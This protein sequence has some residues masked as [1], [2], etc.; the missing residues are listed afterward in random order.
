MEL[1]YMDYSVDSAVHPIRTVTERA[2]NGA[3][4]VEPLEFDCESVLFFIL[5]NA[6]IPFRCMTRIMP[7]MYMLSILLWRAYP[8]GSQMNSRRLCRSDPL[9]D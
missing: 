2:D 3:G 4:F 1:G 8:E 9:A 5:G 6:L 7:Y